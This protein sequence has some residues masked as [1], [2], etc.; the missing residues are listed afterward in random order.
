MIQSGR[1]SGELEEGRSGHAV[2]MKRARCNK[3]NDRGAGNY[4]L[5]NH[6]RQEDLTEYLGTQ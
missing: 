2:V 1:E 3:L 4:C 6:Q 5:D